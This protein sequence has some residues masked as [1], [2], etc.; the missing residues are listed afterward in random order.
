VRYRTIFLPRVLYAYGAVVL[1]RRL[2][3]RVRELCAAAVSGRNDENEQRRSLQKLK[4]ALQAHTQH[5]KRVAA[6]KLV[7]KEDGFQERDARLSFRHGEWAWQDAVFGGMIL[8]SVVGFVYLFT[9]K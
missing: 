2:E 6:L 7:E 9:H 5:L 4:A 1:N 3:D 8:A